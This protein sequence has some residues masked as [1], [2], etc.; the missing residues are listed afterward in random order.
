MRRSAASVGLLV[1]MRLAKETVQ[2]VQFAAAIQMIGGPPPVARAL[3]KV[4][5]VELSSPRAAAEPKQYFKKS[6]L[7]TFTATPFPLF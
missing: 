6:L 1:E 3:S 4:P 5:R 2:P 7:D